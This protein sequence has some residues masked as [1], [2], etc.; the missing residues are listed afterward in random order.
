M[1]NN[2][3]TGNQLQGRTVKLD[4]TTV[5]TNWNE[6]RIALPENLAEK[7]GGVKETKKLIKEQKQ[8]GS[9][10]STFALP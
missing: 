4:G 3:S 10:L 9:S 1:K 5:I 6:I 8:T 2:K 7:I